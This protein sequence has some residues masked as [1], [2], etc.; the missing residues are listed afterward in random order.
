M[1]KIKTELTLNRIIDSLTKIGFKADSYTPSAQVKALSYLN[2]D[3]AF[4][5]VDNNDNLSSSQK[6]DLC[7]KLFTV[8]KE[9]YFIYKAGNL[10]PDYHF[11][12]WVT[13]SLT[14]EGFDPVAIR[15]KIGHS[16]DKTIVKDFFNSLELTEKDLN[17]DYA[18][19]YDLIPFDKISALRDVF[20]P[21]AVQVEQ[22]AEK[23]LGW[24][25]KTIE[26]AYDNAVE[27][28][29]FENG[30]L[31]GVLSPKYDDNT[32]QNALEKGFATTQKGTNGVKLLDHKLLE[33]KIK[34]DARL[35][36][37]IVHKNDLGDYLAVFDEQTNHKGIDN[38]LHLN[39][40]KNA[41][42]IFIDEDCYSVPHCY[43]NEL[44]DTQ[45]AV[46]G[47]AVDCY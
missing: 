14:K 24:Y 43:L 4:A 46:I 8:T 19:F 7:F 38:I 36:S 2:N 6:A 3:K 16:W 29:D 21:S 15:S 18:V 41:K 9:P 12:A 44:A 31:Y 32:W 1:T 22:S 13:A 33:L 47:E 35:Y 39:A 45:T 26:I 28:G 11:V 23:A 10:S 37:K 30:K 40:I 27:I 25:G 34:G 17:E 5:R 42:S 20:K